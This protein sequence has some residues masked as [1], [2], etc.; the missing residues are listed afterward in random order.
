VTAPDFQ[1]LLRGRGGG[2]TT[3]AMRWVAG[4]TRVPGYP[5]WS[6]VLVAANRTMFDHL[7]REWWGLLEDLDHRVYAYDDWVRAR[8]VSHGTEVR[9]DDAERLLPRLPARLT[10]V[11]MSGDMWDTS[12]SRP[13]EGEAAVGLSDA[14]GADPHV[15]LDLTFPPNRDE[16]P[17]CWTCGL[18]WPTT[19][20][21]TGVATDEQVATMLDDPDSWVSGLEHEVRRLRAGGDGPPTCSTCSGAG[22]IA[23]E[24]QIGV[25]GSGCHLTCPDCGPTP[26]VVVDDDEL[27]PSQSD[28]GGE[29]RG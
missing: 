9:L 25:P 6:R 13:L 5:G 27:P 20:T 10:G 26:S 22:I 1:V 17:Q 16:L 7:R 2:K 21:C 19:G 15:P 8:G 11:T 12:A 24:G 18:P 3:E 28:E 4:G 14:S 23:Q 29:P